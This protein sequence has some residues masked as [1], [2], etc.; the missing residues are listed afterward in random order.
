MLLMETQVSRVVVY[1]QSLS[2]VQPLLEKAVI[3]MARYQDLLGQ[4]TWLSLFEECA[5]IHRTYYWSTEKMTQ[6]NLEKRIMVKL[7]TLKI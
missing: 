4:E 5:G 6:M 1:Q 3:V 2:K 7:E